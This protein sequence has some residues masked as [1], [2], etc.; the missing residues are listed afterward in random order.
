M[1]KSSRA[2]SRAFISWRERCP[3]IGLMDPDRNGDMISINGVRLDLV[4]HTIVVLSRLTR[5]AMGRI[6]AEGLMTFTA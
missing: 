4:S 3:V 1:F 2:S 5:L 6:L